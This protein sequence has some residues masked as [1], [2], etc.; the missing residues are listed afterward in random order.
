MSNKPEKKSLEKAYDALDDE[1]WDTA[2]RLFAD[3]YA[4]SGH[5]PSGY[6]AAILYFASGKTETALAI[7]NELYTKYTYM[8]KLTAT[9][10]Y[11]IEDSFLNLNFP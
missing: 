10:S 11:L 2:L 1:N 3:E 7:S 6:N 8:K 4:K 9:K 5:I